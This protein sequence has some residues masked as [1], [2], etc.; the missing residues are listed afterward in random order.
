MVN[1]KSSDGIKLVAAFLLLF[2]L[3][4]SASKLAFVLVDDDD[5]VSTIEGSAKTLSPEI[6]T[7]NHVFVASIFFAALTLPL[8]FFAMTE[9]A[10]A[11]SAR[12]GHRAF[13]YI[14]PPPTSA[15]TL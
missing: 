1:V 15:Q 13:Q 10:P 11:P 5:Q 9:M 6:S 4:A 8:V 12:P 7:H 14:R 3:L 2:A